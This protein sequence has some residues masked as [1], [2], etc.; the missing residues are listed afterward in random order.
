M[1]RGVKRWTL[2][3]YFLVVASY[4][5]SALDFGRQNGHV[6]NTREEHH[7]HQVG[8]HQVG[9]EEIKVASH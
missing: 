8:I 5:V 1:K 6:L 9:N 7:M 2:I 3:A 4:R